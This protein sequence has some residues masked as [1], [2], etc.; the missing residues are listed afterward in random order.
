MLRHEYGIVGSA[1]GPSRS[2]PTL[3]QVASRPSR[4]IK[5]IQLTATS[6][7]LG[8]L[9]DRNSASTL[10]PSLALLAEELISEDT[11]NT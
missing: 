6:M 9:E 3:Q 11:S 1:L 7:A 4:E 2:D 10:M 5:A 8:G